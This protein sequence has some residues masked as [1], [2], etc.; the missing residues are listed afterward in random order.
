MLY[1]VI[2]DIHGNYPALRAVLEDAR[3]AG[4]Q[5][6][7]LLGDFLTDWPFTREVLETLASLGNA[8]FVSGNREWYLDFL[9][10][11]H[12]HRE[13]FAALFLTRE[14]MGE[15]ALSWVRSLPKS[16]RLSTPDGVGS[17]FLEHIPPVGVGESGGKSPASGELDERFPTRDASHQEVAQYVRESFLKLPHL[18]EVLQRVNAPVYLHG[19]SHLQ[20]A[21]EV[22]GTLF[23]NP[24]SCGLPLDHQPGAPY[25]LLRFESGRFQVEERRVPYDV[26]ETIAAARNSPAYQQ[27]AGWYQLNSWQL[28]TARDCNRVFFRFLQ[29]EQQRSSPQTD[30]EHNLVFHKALA[31]AQAACQQRKPARDL[32]RTT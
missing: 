18:P 23:L 32:P 19:H 11:A 28:R 22:G 5:Q 31:L 17:L 13:Q 25:T 29:E 30:Q 9:H 8:V 26:E 16:T 27:A 10:P 15:R 4:A 1:A 20:Y 14:A 2:A 6:Y 12:R 3:E 21:V 7:L 24:G